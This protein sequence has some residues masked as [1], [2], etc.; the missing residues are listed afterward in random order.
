ME[1]KNDL[2]ARW[3]EPFPGHEERFEMRLM[4][5]ELAHKKRPTQQLWWIG[6]AAA[7]A[8]GA[9]V[10]VAINEIK[11]ADDLVALNKVDA[12]EEVMAMDSVFRAHTGGRLPEVKQKDQYSTRILGEVTR[13]EEEYKKMEDNLTNGADP[14]RITN[15]M[16]KNYQFRIRLIEQLRQYL[17]IKEQ[18]KN[19]DEKI[20]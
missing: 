18:I 8:V 1:E 11:K 14:E 2:K 16:V 7:L 17:M 19:N 13:L 20:S 4:K 5:R 3:P 6:I 9:I 15:E 12:N 10:S